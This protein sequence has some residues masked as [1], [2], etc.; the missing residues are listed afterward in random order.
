MLNGHDND[1]FRREI[2]RNPGVSE[3]QRAQARVGTG[4][5]EEEHR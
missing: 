2:L 3:Q 4:M 5:D 1:I